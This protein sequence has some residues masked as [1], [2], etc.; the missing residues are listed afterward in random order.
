M[1]DGVDAAQRLRHVLRPGEVADDRS[2]GLRWQGRRP[3]QKRLHPVAAPGQ[4]AQQVPSNEAGRAGQSDE[5]N[6]HAAAR[7]RRGVA[8]RF[9][10]RPTKPAP[11]RSAP[12]WT[13]QV[14]QASASMARTAS[15][16]LRPNTYAATAV[17]A[18]PWS[19]AC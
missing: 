2:G 4:L 17:T 1:D 10:T 18:K 8:N 16:R 14:G 11:A 12:A 3:A 15:S 13:G 5:R 7:A 6:V 9:R 19:T